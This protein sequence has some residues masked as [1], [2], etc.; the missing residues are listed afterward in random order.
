MKFYRGMKSKK[1]IAGW[2]ALVTGIVALVTACIYLTIAMGSGRTE[3][4]CSAANACA[5]TEVQGCKGC[6][7]LPSTI[8][9]SLDE[10]HGQNPSAICQAPSKNESSI[11]P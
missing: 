3:Y 4:Q 9:G 5:K 6:Q 8:S 11:A 7:L 1:K 2:I 10:A